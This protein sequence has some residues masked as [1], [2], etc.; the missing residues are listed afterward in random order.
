[1]NPPQAFKEQYKIYIKWLNDNYFL[2]T[3]RDINY[4]F[5]DIKKS[6]CEHYQILLVA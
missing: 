6:S 2:R 1:M 4:F 5:A 3:S